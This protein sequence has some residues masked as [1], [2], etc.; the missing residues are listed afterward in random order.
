MDIGDR[1]RE[2]RRR[3]GWTQE[4]LANAVRVD[5]SA[6]GQWETRGKARSGITTGHLREVASV[7][8]IPASELIDDP[9]SDPTANPADPRE[10][11]LIA[12]YR[13][14]PPYQQDIMLNIFYTTV[15][16]TQKKKPGG[17][18]KKRRPRAA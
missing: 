10:M 14:M 5:P 15:G 1:I 16:I 17:H 8:G 9:P 7:L 2:A 6:V 4:Q 11:A 3:V 13:R 12:L 18:P